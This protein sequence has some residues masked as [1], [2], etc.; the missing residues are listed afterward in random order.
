MHYRRVP[1]FLIH[2][3]HLC[4]TVFRL[5][6]DK[7]VRKFNLY[8]RRICLAALLVA[9]LVASF[10]C[11]CAYNLRGV[12]HCPLLNRNARKK[13]GENNRKIENGSVGECGWRETSVQTVSS[14]TLHKFIPAVPVHV[15]RRRRSSFNWYRSREKSRVVNRYD[16][17]IYRRIDALL[18]VETDVATREKHLRNNLNVCSPPPLKCSPLLAWPP[19]DSRYRR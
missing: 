14:C 7:I 2:F 15:L 10:V 6:I 11:V 3:A 9:I 5:K 12:V 19:D 18:S 16:R 8:G 4:V 13:K 1:F 17:W